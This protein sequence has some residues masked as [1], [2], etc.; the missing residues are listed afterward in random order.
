MKIL[1]IAPGFAPYEFSENIVNS[2]LVLALIQS[3]HYVD[4]ITKVDEGN[5]YSN[6]WIYP[7]SE[8]ESITTIPVYARETPFK[9]L[10][11]IGVSSYKFRTAMEGIRWAARAYKIA[12]QKI[13]STQ[14]DVMM[15][16]SPADIG[17]LVGLKLKKQTGL[18]WI[19]N[20]NDPAVTIWPGEYKTRLSAFQRYFYRNL[21]QDVIKYC[22]LM[23]FPCKELRDHFALKFHIK[24][25]KTRVIPHINLAKAININALVS[26]G[27]VRMCHAGN[28]SRERRPENLFLAL[29]DVIKKNPDVFIKLDIIGS[30]HEDFE[31]MIRSLDLHQNIES[32]GSMS[33][34]KTMEA[35]NN[36]D[37][38]VVLEA[39]VEVGIFLPSKIVD[40]SQL[41]KPIL[42]I[43]PVV[44]CLSRM[45]NCYGG[46]MAVN[47]ESQEDISKGLQKYIESW[48]KGMLAEMFD[49]TRLNSNFDVADIVQE[50]E[51]AID[52]VKINGH[53]G[54]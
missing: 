3:G 14:Y 38:L 11:D 31:D 28:L 23:T 26:H 17:H 18:P 9:R 4:V 1:F 16:R 13:G 34:G 35:L 10:L 21:A 54:C 24:K 27:I 29:K 30:I 50:Y 44:G 6:S 46:G 8:L 37:I 52:I 12:L 53:G 19:A 40:Y 15:T 2:K 25:E 47:C 45:M 32:I 20:W 5:V 7:W 33:Y 48:R 43:S 51:K 36:Y 39:P 42:S 49:S 41:H 22:D